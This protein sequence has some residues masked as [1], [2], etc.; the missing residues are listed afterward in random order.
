MAKNRNRKHA[1]RQAPAARPKEEAAQA[2]S[3]A[4]RTVELPGEASPGA[5]GRGRP[6]RFGHN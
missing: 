5:G 1:A 2:K 3:P 4:A 6:R